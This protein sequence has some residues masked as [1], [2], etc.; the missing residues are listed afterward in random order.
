MNIKFQLQEIRNK[1][2]AIVYSFR[3][4]SALGFDH[5]DYWKMDVVSSWASAVEQLK[6]IP[7]ILDVRTFCWKAMNES[8]PHIDYVINLN[9]GNNSLSTLGLVPSVCGFLSIPCIPSGTIQ[10][11]TGEDKY[12]SNLVAK[13]LDIRLPINS[14]DT[15]ELGIYRPNNLG[16]SSGVKR[17]NKKHNDRDLLQ[18]FIPGYDMTTPLLFNPMTKQIDVLPSIICSSKSYDVNWIFDENAKKDQSNIIK[19]C[20]KTDETTK[21]KFLNMTKSFDIKTYCRIDTRILSKNNQILSSIIKNIIPYEKIFF[22]E[23]NAMPTISTSTNF[24]YSLTKIEKDSSFFEPFV[25]FKEELVNS[26]VTGFILFCSLCSL[27]ET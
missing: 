17:T 3:N 22:L 2:I 1:T 9:A 27:M 12:I 15:T 10:A 24:C 19:H 21:K 14:T 7:F 6:C 25:Y 20:V 13:S 18:E 16:S 26:S 5:Y 8:L 23:M 4:E 11:V